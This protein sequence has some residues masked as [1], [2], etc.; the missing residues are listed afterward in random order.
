MRRF[1]DRIAERPVAHALLIILSS[2]LVSEIAR[3]VVKGPQAGTWLTSLA[4]ICLFTAAF[5]GVVWW[6]GRRAK[7]RI[8]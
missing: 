3:A 5:V 4:H 2:F 6:L 8:L 1:A 7:Q